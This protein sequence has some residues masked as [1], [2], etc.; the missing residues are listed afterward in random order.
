ML[1]G[2]ASLVIR[3]RNKEIELNIE[4]SLLYWSNLLAFNINI[5]F[6]NIRTCFIDEEDYIER[7]VLLETRWNQGCG[8]ND[9]LA[10]SCNNFFCNRP[11]VGCVATAMAQILKY[12]A[13]NGWDG[14]YILANGTDS[15]FINW[16]NMPLTGVNVNNNGHIPLL[17][18]HLGQMLDMIYSCD[19]S[20]AYSSD[21]QTS[22]INNFSFSNATLKVINSASD[23]NVVFADIFNDLPVY[24]S[25][26][27]EVT[28][29][30]ENDEIRIRY[31]GHA[32]VADG[33][34]QLYRCGEGFI[35]N[36]FELHMNWGWGGF[37]DGYYV[38]K[39]GL[40]EL[41][42]NVIHNIALTD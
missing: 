33:Y 38:K 8:Y 13:D 6:L 19:G 23:Y 17:M 22:F 2:Y 39:E 29:L 32:W 14:N 18:L 41:R 9:W 30:L 15:P 35:D 11:P 36:Q 24:M 1:N 16:E 26:R 34:S 21:A 4:E 28:E 10:D 31:P 7:K 3:I 5:L 37:G 27:K 25:G 12:H 40:F 42:R 20:G